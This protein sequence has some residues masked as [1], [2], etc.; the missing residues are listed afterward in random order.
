MFNKDDLVRASAFFEY[1]TYRIKKFEIIGVVTAVL[2]TT[3]IIKDSDK[4][5]HE[6]AKFECTKIGRVTKWKTK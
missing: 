4:M 2:S 1:N 6:F 3:V 5:H